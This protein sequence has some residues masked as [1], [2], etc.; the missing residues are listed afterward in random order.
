VANITADMGPIFDLTND[1]LDSNA[2]VKVHSV[3]NFKYNNSTLLHLRDSDENV[4][5]PKNFSQYQIGISEF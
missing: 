4:F 2:T 3:P 1:A 5:E